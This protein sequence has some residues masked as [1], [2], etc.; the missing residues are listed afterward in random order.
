MATTGWW[1][2]GLCLVGGV[3][4]GAAAVLLLSRNSGTVRKGVASMLSHSMDVKD[5]IKGA[6]AVAKE[7]LEDIAAEAR[8]ESE[9]RRAAK[10]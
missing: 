3:A 8:H 2:C 7:N 5:K 10:S 9:K 4:V 6:A 1:K